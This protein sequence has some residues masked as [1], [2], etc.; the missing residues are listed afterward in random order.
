MNP[1]AS[2]TSP[3]VLSDTTQSLSLM[4][5]RPAPMPATTPFVLFEATHDSRSSEAAVV[6]A[7][8]L[9]CP[10]GELFDQATGDAWREERIAGDDG[11]DMPAGERGEIWIKGPTVM[12]RGCWQRPDANAAVFTDGWFH[13]GDVGYMDADGFVYL[14]DRAKDMIIRAGENIYCVEVENV[15]FD[16]PDVIDA[17]VVGVPHKVMGE[18]V[19]AV[20]QLKPGSTATADDIRAFATQHFLP[21]LPVALRA[22]PAG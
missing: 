6:V 7:F 5:A 19:K 16:F 9:S 3:F 1:F 13:S 11:R 18:E 20:V 14:V 15:L 4:K 22:V 10:C 12:N 17:A 8:G 2:L 21:S